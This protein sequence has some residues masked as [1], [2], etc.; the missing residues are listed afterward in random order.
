MNAAPRPTAPGPAMFPEELIQEDRILLDDHATSKKKVLEE[1]A[2]LLA[3]EG[4]P[5]GA[6][7]IYE[8]LLERERLGSTGMS[9][10]VALPHAR[11]RGLKR[12]RGAFLRLARPVDFDALDGGPVDL[13]F[14]LLVP[15]EAT[16]EHLALLAELARLFADEAACDRFRRVQDPAGVL[17]LLY[18]DP[19]PDAASGHS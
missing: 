1:L 7:L 15:E 2:R 4:K 19:L 14:G 13:V 5:P 17:R 12:P 9:H 16:E 6:E 18:P 3:V 11:I 8:K 10:G